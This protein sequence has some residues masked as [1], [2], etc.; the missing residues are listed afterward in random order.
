MKIDLLT[1]QAPR[2]VNNFVFLATH[3]FYNGLTWNQVRY[4]QLIQTG[5]PNDDERR[6]PNDAGYRI[7]DELPND[8][9][10]YVYGAVGMANAGAPD[11][12]GSQFFIV[13]NDLKGAL[14]GTPQPLGIGRTYTVFGRVEKRY[15]GSVEN[16]ARQATVGGADSV[17]SARPVSP[18]YV[19]SIRILR[20]PPSS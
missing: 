20:T 18:I 2:A 1:G 19:E 6:A 9:S 5:D 10:P 13:A 11:S 14:K 3:G 4:D 17:E 16:I 12:G 8:K 7:K 15:F